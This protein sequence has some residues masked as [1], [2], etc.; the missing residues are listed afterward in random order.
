MD[1]ATTYRAGCFCCTNT[2]SS[3]QAGMQELVV[4]LQTASFD[5]SQFKPEKI[6]IIVPTRSLRQCFEITTRCRH[7]RGYPTFP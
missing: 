7:L 5:K 6:Y 4:C 2:N 3:K 1:A